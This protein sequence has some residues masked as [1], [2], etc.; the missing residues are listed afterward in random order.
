MR[1]KDDVR[2]RAVD[3]ATGAD[4]VKKENLP[5][6][7]QVKNFG[8]SGQTKY[9]HLADQDTSN[10]ESGWFKKRDLYV[11]CYTAPRNLCH[12]THVPL[13][14]STLRTFFHCCGKQHSGQ[15]EAQDGW[16]AWRLGHCWACKAWIQQATTAIARGAFLVIH[17]DFKCIMYDDIAFSRQASLA[18]SVALCLGKS[19]WHAEWRCAAF[20]QYR[21]GHCALVEVHGVVVI[22]EREH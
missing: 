11:W 1:V 18:V 4:M 10:W 7:M 3:G 22:E 20:I 6:V 13:T 5:K 8:R 19:L 15:D 21:E 16:R 9:T 12:Y 17:C 14:C 2:K